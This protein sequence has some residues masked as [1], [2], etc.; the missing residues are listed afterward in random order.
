MEVSPRGIA[1]L[2]LVQSIARW[3]GDTFSHA[4]GNPNDRNPHPPPLV[5]IQP[6]SDHPHKP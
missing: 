6:Y 1:M 3:L 2:R 4:L 5:G